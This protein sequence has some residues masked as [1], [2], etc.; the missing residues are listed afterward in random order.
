MKIV[1]VKQGSAEWLRARAGVLTASEFDNLISPTFKRREGQMP[2]TYILRKIAEQIMGLPIEQGGAWATD[3]G[4]ILEGEAIPWLEFTHNLS[5]DRVGFVTSDDGRVGCSPDGLIGEDGGVEVKC[6]QPVNHLRYL[7]EGGVPADYLLQVHGSLYVTGRKWWLFVSYS[8]QFP[9]VMVRVERDEKI[10]AK[11]DEVL[12]ATLD[13]FETK[14]AKVR[15]L[16]VEYDGPKIAAGRERDAKEE[17]AARAALGG[18]E[19]PGE[20]WLRENGRIS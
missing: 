5:I 3:Q 15:A 19:L 18:G 1:D 11:I 14:L 20:K 17:A 10:I 12:M 2:Q 8:R 9:P 13:E 6:P 16:K 4:A 7:L